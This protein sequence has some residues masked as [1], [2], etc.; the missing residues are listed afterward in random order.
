[1]VINRPRRGREHRKYGEEVTYHQ[2]QHFR[3]RG[4]RGECASNLKPVS[5]TNRRYINTFDH[6]LL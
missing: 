3:R 1:M 2:V 5:V 4:R 6:M